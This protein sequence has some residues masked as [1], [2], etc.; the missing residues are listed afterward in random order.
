MIVQDGGTPNIA[1]ITNSYAFVKLESSPDDGIYDAMNRAIL[2]SSGDALWFLNGGDLAATYDLSKILALIQENPGAMIFGDYELNTG[3]A[4]VLRKARPQTYIRHGLPTSHQ[5]IIYPAEIARTTLY[6]LRYKITGDYAF[7]ASLIVSG[8]QS[9][10]P[11][12]VLAI[13][14]AGGTSQQ[15]SRL[16]AREAS[17]VQRDILQVGPIERSV[18]A[19]RHFA[20]RSLRSL[21]TRIRS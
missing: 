11:G 3:R 20:S 17:I 13:F 5:A 21:Q 7:T 12:I 19:T 14:A 16:I 2:R 18:S 1:S 10:R 15:H 4:L 6:D 9:V 8:T